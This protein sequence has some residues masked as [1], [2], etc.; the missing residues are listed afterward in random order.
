MGEQIC[1]TYNAHL[2]C[3]TCNLAIYAP[4]FN[5]NAIKQ[6][7]S[8]YIYCPNG[9]ANR[10][11]HESRV[12]KLERDIEGFKKTIAFWRRSAINKENEIRAYKGHVTRLRNRLNASI[13]NDN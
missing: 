9:H 13:Q 12:Q 6:G 11:P 7:P 3:N 8:P 5:Y 4:D 2:H 10:L 1:T